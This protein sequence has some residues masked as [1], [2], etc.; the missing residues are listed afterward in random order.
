MPPKRRP[1]ATASSAAKA[2]PKKRPSKLAKE[3]DLTA[4]QEAEIQEAFALFSV[5]D[6]PDFEDEKEGAIKI[7]DVRRCLIALNTPPNSQSELSEILSTL[8]PSGVGYVSYPHFLAVAALKLHSKHDSP[9]AQAEEVET[10]FQ[11]FT[12]G[13]GE[14]ITLAM[15]RR[16]A[17]ELREDVGDAVLKDMLREA[18]GGASVGEGIGREE[19]EDV[20]RRAGVFA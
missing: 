11:L 6:H 4:D 17:R 2:A 19:F 20:M 9:D 14:T 10:A 16:V 5:Q 8:D 13:E 7:E 15:L 12:R 18:N 3:N 1:P